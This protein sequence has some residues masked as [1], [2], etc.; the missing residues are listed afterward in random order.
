MKIHTEWHQHVETWRE[1][2]LSQADYCR[3][4][5][6]NPKTFTM[7]TRRIRRELSLDKNALL[8]IIPVQVES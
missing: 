4:Q 6:L 7:W 2:S 3:P 5:N 8:E 1:S